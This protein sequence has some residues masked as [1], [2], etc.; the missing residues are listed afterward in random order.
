M[1][2]VRTS[3]FIDGR[4]GRARKN[5]IRHVRRRVLS[6]L[7]RLRQAPANRQIVG[8]R[9]CLRVLMFFARQSFRPSVPIVFNCGG[10]VTEE[11]THSRIARPEFSMPTGARMGGGV[12]W[13]G[14]VHEIQFMPPLTLKRVF[15][16]SIITRTP[17]VFRAKRTTTYIRAHVSFRARSNKSVRRYRTWRRGPYIRRF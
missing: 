2:S 4:Y 14:F 10:N 12:R 1:T 6:S 13:R 7:P 5:R 16:L 15:P 3:V 8:T 9:R 11:I 17:L